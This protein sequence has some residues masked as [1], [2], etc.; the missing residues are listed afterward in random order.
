M[1]TLLCGSCLAVL[2]TSRRDALNVMRAHAVESTHPLT[3]C[4]DV[5]AT[6]ERIVA[7]SFG[8]RL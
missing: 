8:V 6:F 1:R 3:R 5:D 4:L 2:T 7:L